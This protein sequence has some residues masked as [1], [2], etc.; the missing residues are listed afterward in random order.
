MFKAKEETNTLCDSALVNI[1]I[2]ISARREL[3]L[4]VQIQVLVK[5]PKQYMFGKC[6]Q[7]LLSNQG[8]GR[9]VC[10]QSAETRLSVANKDT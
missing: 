2:K 1:T 8:Q 5:H 3:S 7:S 6:M 10:F 9:M 4:H